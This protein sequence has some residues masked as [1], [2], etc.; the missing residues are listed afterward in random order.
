VKARLSK[1]FSR[2]IFL[3]QSI[4]YQHKILSNYS[5]KILEDAVN[6]FARLPGIGRRTALRLVLHLL[7]E[8]PE[9]VQRFGNTFLRLRNEIR[10]CRQCHNIS[11]TEVCTICSSSKRD[12]SLLC[13][14]ED[15]RD[16]IAIENTNQFNGKYHV[17]GGIISPMDGIGP[18]DLN[19]ETLLHKI[20][21]NGIKEVIMALSATMEGDTTVF[22]LYKKIF[23]LN[24]G[25]L[26]ISAIARGVSVGDEL[27]YA[28][29][30]TLGRSIMNRTPYENSLVR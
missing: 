25:D 22:Y 1:Y 8:S 24:C 11:E 30:A 26:K 6:Q 15:V 13:I 14:V 21:S 12:E 23:Q 28:D 7:K 3:S 17:L 4:T 18:G 2:K 27:E 5:S 10:Y 16:V 19:I 20:S 29:E 9:E